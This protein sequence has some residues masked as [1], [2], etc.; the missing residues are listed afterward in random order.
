ME[1]RRA[2]YG[3]TIR[4][5]QLVASFFIGRFFRLEGSSHPEEITGATF[6]N[7]LRAGATTFAAMVYIISVIVR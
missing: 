3:T 1:I 7:E 5:N 6:L 4:F 2:I